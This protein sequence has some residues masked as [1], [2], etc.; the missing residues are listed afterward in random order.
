MRQNAEKRNHTKEQISP[1]LKRAVFSS[2]LL[3]AIWFGKPV[4]GQP[5]S[6]GSGTETTQKIS[7]AVRSEAVRKSHAQENSTENEETTAADGFCLEA[8]TENPA[9]Q[10]AAREQLKSLTLEEKIG[11]IFI[12]ICRGFG[13]RVIAHDMYPNK[14]LDFVEY[15]SMDTLLAESDLISLHCPLTSDNYHMINNYTISKIKKHPVLV[16]TSR[17][18]LIDTEDL[19]RGIRADKFFGVGLDVY[20]EETQNVFENREDDILQSSIVSRLLSFPNVIVT[21]HQAFLT[22]EALEAISRTTLDN[23]KAF[24]AGN[25]DPKNVVSA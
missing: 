18:A 25:P 12:R 11:Q 9:L 22:E 24:V 3:A 14:N 15:V 21:S 5:V 10:K 7:S 20:E 13:M 2:F 4:S 8:L 23:A 6:S 17:G 16:N 19:I 1:F